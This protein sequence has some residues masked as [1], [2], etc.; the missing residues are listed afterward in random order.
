MKKKRYEK[1]A[2]ENVKK[3][4]QGKGRLWKMKEYAKWRL[5]K[6]SAGRRSAERKNGNWRMKK[7][8]EKENEEK[9]LYKC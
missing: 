4:K 9:E 5:E 6:E 1:E 8:A 7:S 2:E 3:R